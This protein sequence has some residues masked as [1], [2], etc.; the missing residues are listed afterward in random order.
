MLGSCPLFLGFLHFLLPFCNFFL[1]IFRSKTGL[2]HFWPTFSGHEI[3]QKILGDARPLHPLKYQNCSFNKGIR[4]N[5]PHHFSFLLPIEQKSSFLLYHATHPHVSLFSAYLS[6]YLQ[7]L[8]RTTTSGISLA[9]SIAKSRSMQRVGLRS[10]L[11]APHLSQ[12]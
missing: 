1:I 4:I 5:Q 3:G 12:I 10:Q 6:A 2:A 9:Q 7:S 8:H 11:S